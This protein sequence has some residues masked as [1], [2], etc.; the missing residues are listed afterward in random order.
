MIS[1]DILFKYYNS[2]RMRVAHAPYNRYN[3]DCNNSRYNYD[4]NRYSRGYNN[5]YNYY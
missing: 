1:N 4:C 3:Y 2:R 5:Y